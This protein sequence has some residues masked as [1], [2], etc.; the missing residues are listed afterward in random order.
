MPRFGYLLGHYNFVLFIGS[1]YVCRNLRKFRDLK[2]VFI[3]H[4][5]FFHNAERNECWTRDFEEDYYRKIDFRVNGNFLKISEL[6]WDRIYIVFLHFSFRRSSH[7]ITVRRIF[8]EITYTCTLLF[9]VLY[10][11]IV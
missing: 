6:S 8:K 2:K 7:I 9:C 3:F 1:H 10:S 11:L 4:D 5:D